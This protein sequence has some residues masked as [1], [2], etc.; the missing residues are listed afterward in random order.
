M[1]FYATSRRLS[2]DAACVEFDQRHFTI[3]AFSH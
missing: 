1:S 3:V 2:A